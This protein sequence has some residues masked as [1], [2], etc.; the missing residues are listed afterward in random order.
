ML[1][2]LA[3]VQQVRGEPLRRW[4]FCHEMDL[5]IWENP[6]GSISAFQLAYDK[7]HKEHSLYWRQDKGFAHFVVDDGEPLAEENDTPL[8]RANGPFR[9]FRVLRDFVSLASKIPPPIRSFVEEKLREYS[10]RHDL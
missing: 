2:E 4:F 5:V 6:D 10:G 3:N 1:R 7:P 8:L 9:Q